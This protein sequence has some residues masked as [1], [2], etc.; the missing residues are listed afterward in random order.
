MTSYIIIGWC[1]GL[2]AGMVLWVAFPEAVYKTVDHTL[3][4][5]KIIR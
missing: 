5:L 3:R 2:L 4:L 1:L